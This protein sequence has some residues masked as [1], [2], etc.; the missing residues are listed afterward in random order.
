MWFRRNRMWLS[1]ILLLLVMLLV[2]TSGLTSFGCAGIRSV[3]EGGSGG[4]V[5]NGTIFLYPALEQGSGGFSCTPSTAEGKLIALNISGSRLWE[6]PLETAKPARGMFSCAA[7]PPPMVVYGSPAVAGGLVYVGGYN[8][9]VYAVNDSTGS[10][11]W[12]YP[13]QGELE[14]IVGGVV[15]VGG[16]LYFGGSDGKVYA[17][18]AETGDKKWEFQ[19]GDKIWSSPT[20][21]GDTLFIG[22]LDKKLYALSITDG[23]KQW[24]FETEGSIASTSIVYGNT[25]YVGTKAPH[26]VI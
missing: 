5:A 2:V 25:V 20:I 9:K 23:S 13:R 12:V 8:G 3:P 15:V 18:D 26:P 14:P 19:T 22:S 16:E 4:T 24:E 11:R 6:V 7:P 21:D 10:L 17:L 1:K